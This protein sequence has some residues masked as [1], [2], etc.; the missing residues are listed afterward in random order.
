MGILLGCPN[1]TSKLLTSLIMAPESEAVPKSS[2]RMDPDLIAHFAANPHLQAMPTKDDLETTNS[3][4]TRLNSIIQTLLAQLEPLPEHITETKHSITSYDGATINVHEFA[5]NDCPETREPGPAFLYFHGGGT[6][7]CPIDPVF[8]PAI[9]KFASDFN[10]RTFGVEYRLAPEHP[11]PTP[12]EDCYAAVEWVYKNSTTLNVDYRRIG[13]YGESA[14]GN[15]AA[16][17]ALL[18]RDRHLSPPLAKQMLLYPMVDDSSIEKYPTANDPGVIS[19][20]IARQITNASWEAYLGFGKRGNADV[21]IYAAPSRA[22]ELGGLPSAYID[23]GSLD[24]LRD[25]TLDYAT[26]LARADNEVEV[27]LYAGAPHGFDLYA[28]W[29]PITKNARENRARAVKTV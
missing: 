29:M 16:A 21:S 24:I 2:D 4:R 17:V 26:R 15:L 1:Y 5:R 13:I 20:E 19:P 28:P 7:S 27:H 12:L 8:R 11:Y 9:A 10:I 3:L 18:A 23:C 14:G 6:F 22:T 25:E